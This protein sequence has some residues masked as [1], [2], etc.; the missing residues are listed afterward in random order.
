MSGNHS[1][2]TAVPAG[3]DARRLA[4]TLGLVLSYA[5]AEALGGFFS[6]SLALLA[7]AG[8]MVSDAAAI[9]LTLFA[10]WFARRPSSSSRTFGYHRAEML[11][12]LVNGASL[13][14]IAVLIVVEAIQRLSQPTAVA[15]PLMLAI[16]SGGLLVN[17]AGLYLLRDSDRSNLNMNG[18]WL[19]VLTDALGSVQAIV[20]AVLIALFGW[21]WVDPLASILIAMLVV[22]SS[23]SLLRQSVAVLMEGAPGHIDVDAV[24]EALAA[25]DGVQEV[26]DLHVWTIT[27][28]FVALS[29]HLVVSAGAEA[30]DVLRTSEACLKER[31]RIRHS[32]LQID[33]GGRCAQAHH[34]VHRD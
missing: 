21:Y 5:A 14:G 22:Y 4:W 11:A 20:A 16:A 29:A 18:A 23:W 17:L 13:V 28:G 30:P 24:R 31:F 19:H 6:G 12:A 32:T 34:D 1:H 27:S 10:L 9:A 33:V 25:V 8:H 2:G 3:T 15:G 26:H 7:D